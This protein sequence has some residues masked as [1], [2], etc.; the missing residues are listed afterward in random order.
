MPI[1]NNNI[2]PN[3]H[4]GLRISGVVDFNCGFAIRNFPLH[5]RIAQFLQLRSWP[6]L[7]SPWSQR[8]S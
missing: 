8:L 7:F 6:L 2:R 1:P 3:M 4:K 5:G